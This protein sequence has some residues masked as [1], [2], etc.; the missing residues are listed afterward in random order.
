MKPMHFLISLRIAFP[1]AVTALYIILLIKSK[2]HNIHVYKINSLLVYR[3]KLVLIVKYA[4]LNW[5][6]GK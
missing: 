3:R 6:R 1:L 2:Y 5:Q 4:Q